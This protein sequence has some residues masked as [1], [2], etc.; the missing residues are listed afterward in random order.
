GGRTSVGGEFHT[1][2]LL[3]N[4]SVACWG[5]N[6]YGQLGDGTNTDRNTPV[7]VQNINNAV[8]ISAGQSHTCALLSSG[9]VVCWGRNNYGQLGDGTNTDRNTPVLVQDINN[10]IAIAAGGW[11]TCALLSNGSVACW[12]NNVYGQL[13]NGTFGGYSSTPVLVRGI[14]Y[15]TIAIAAGHMHTCALISSG[16]VACWG[17]NYYGQLG[18]GTNENRNTPTLVQGVNNAVAIS[19]GGWHTCALLSNGSIACWG[20][21]DWGQL[22]NGT[23]GGYSSTPVLVQDINNA[24]AIAAGGWHTCA[25]LA[26]GSVACWGRNNYGQLGDGTNTDRN[27][28][29]LVQNINN[30]VAISAGYYHTCAL[31]SSGLVVCWGRNNYGQ[32]GNGTSG[33]SSPTPVLVLNYNLGGRYDKTG[34]ILT[35][36]RSPSFYDWYFIRKYSPVEPLVLLG[37]E[38]KI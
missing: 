27:T 35:L 22:G 15:N 17:W 24:I 28:P 29:V 37:N 19:A 25:L 6:G 23:F 16:L 26:N 14:Y 8:A 10:A 20:R 30:A 13:G 5:A 7:L 18:D 34:G 3:S 31:L 21:N 38:E 2:A 12:G 9:L 33:G 1:C 11:H 32:L 4:G 36:Q